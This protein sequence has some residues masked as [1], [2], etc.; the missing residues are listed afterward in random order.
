[1]AACSIGVRV[2][3]P[4]IAAL[5]EERRRWPVDRQAGSYLA[6]IEL[7]RQEE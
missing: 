1:M 3:V 2:F 4:S 7:E 6:S 5:L